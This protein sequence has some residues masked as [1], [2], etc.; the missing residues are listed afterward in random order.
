MVDNAYIS[1]IVELANNSITEAHNK[2]K[3]LVEILNNQ[4]K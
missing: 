4:L 3:K 2:V 1:L